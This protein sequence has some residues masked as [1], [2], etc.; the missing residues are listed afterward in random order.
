MRLG[1]QGK[2]ALEHV[3]PDS[4]LWNLH[5]NEPAQGTE[6]VGLG[7]QSG[8]YNCLSSFG[9]VIPFLPTDFSP[10]VALHDFCGALGFPAPRALGARPFP[11][12]FSGGGI[13][14]IRTGRRAK[15]GGAF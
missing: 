12:H 13:R 15:R 1:I 2:G 4:K 6:I 11:V 10:T 14:P 9:A 7:F 3:A 5:Q 8:A